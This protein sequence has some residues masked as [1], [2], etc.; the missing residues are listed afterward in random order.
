MSPIPVSKTKIIPP[1]RRDE[2]LARKRL[3]DM[4]FDALDKKL[5]LVSAP[6]GYGKTSLL[7]DLVK[8]TEL[9]CCW[10]SLDELDREPERFITYFIAS[11]AECFPGVGNQT[12]AVMNGITSL[13]DEMERL[14]V[15]LVNE[16]FALAKEHFVIILDDFHIL[17]DV[18]PIHSLLNRFIQLV[19]DNC[20]IIISSRTLAALPDLPLMVARE[21][22]SGLS[23]FDL[24]FR[25]EEFQA[26]ILQ[27]HRKHISDQ[28]AQKLID[29]TEGWIT[30]LQFSGNNFVHK[31]KSK[32]ILASTGV[33]LFD[34]LGQQVVDKLK[35]ELQ[36][37]LLRTSLMDEFDAQLCEK[38]LAG[39][40]R[41][42]QDWDGYIKA[43]TQN[44][45]FALPVGADGRSLRYHHLFRDYLR[46]R[47]ER[48]KKSEIKV[49]LRNLGN[50]YES[51]GEWEK[52]HYFV[53][54]L[55][56][57]NALAAI[58]E[59]ACFSISQRSLPATETW[60][61]EL[62]PS[63][64][65]NRPGI[66]SI[67]GTLLYMKGDFEKGLAL[68]T[69]AEN[70]FRSEGNSSDLALMLIRRA[71][72]YRFLGN[73]PN[74][75]KDAEEV[76]QITE[77]H[78]TM[79]SLYAEALRVKGLAL[80]RL[81]NSKQSVKFLE[82][83]LDAYI[84]IK[85]QI[86]IPL[87]LMETGM[88]Y[89]SLGK[90]AEASAAYE[91]AL[92]IWKQE[93]N[94][95]RQSN[96][97]NNMGVMYHIQGEYG[98]SASAYE[99]GLLCARRSSYKRLEALISIG[100]GDL[101]AELQDFEIASQNYQ[102]ASTLI[103]EMQEHFLL[104]SLQIGQ[105]NMAL[106]QN[107]KEK[108]SEILN[109][110]GEKM[111]L[112]Q[113]HYEN[114]N[115]HLLSGKKFILEKR[116]SQAV[117][118]LEQAE[119]HFIED[120]RELECSITRIWLAAAFYS[121]NDAANAS[122]KLKMAIND[123]SKV[124]PGL[125]VAICQARLWLEGLERDAEIGRLLRDLFVRSDRLTD[126]LPSIRRELRRQSRVLEMPAP[127]LSIH[128]LGRS[129]V[130]IAGHV[131]NISD[132]QTQSVRDLFFFF[133][134]KS[135]PLT[136]EQ[137]AEIIWPDI[138]EP[139]KIRLRFKNEIYRLRRAIGQEAILFEN[140]FY[141]FNRS[142]DYEYDVEAFESYL[143]KIKSVKSVE[144][145]IE[146]Y[147]KA[148]DLVHGPYLEDM[149]FDWI[150]PDRE[151]LS[152]MYLNAL[153]ALADLYQKRALLEEGLSLCRRAI[154]YRPTFEAAYTLSMQ[155]YHRLGDRP[156]IIRM[157]QA[158]LDALQKLSMDPSNE[159]L[160]LYQTLIS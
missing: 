15:T 91:K 10:L 127:H 112:N 114:G 82:N 84:A 95:L 150:F 157:Y 54:Q 109:E 141:S 16:C 79:R 123:G 7:I 59:R 20:H 108:A 97:L 158:C 13:E 131:L 111:S 77:G 160:T 72:G 154:D 65:N 51:M 151:R 145:Q 155:I 53:K 152:Q 69:Q 58:I 34:F 122:K 120:G 68:F 126:S 87:L 153:V 66:L 83:S 62:P 128:A 18:K 2:L 30:G 11:I 76:I 52:A 113:S 74:S 14:A 9:R 78:D 33:G 106:L 118:S 23:F 22:V 129:A 88:A 27:N 73:Y 89:D 55:D 57:M 1:R 137:I 42:K 19:D 35:P 32:P 100:L 3:L 142:M 4:L 90:Y 86:G 102:H 38:V 80:F 39:F 75:I 21:Q 12:L 121:N 94:L 56:D 70:I 140:V 63:I 28:D 116:M 133:L 17:E 115:F 47:M 104:F 139:S 99:D 93:G 64:L 110:M 149:Y 85:D 71:S 46:V 136:K 61:N 135:K 36:E 25:K 5:V 138:D 134:T 60:L 37:F 119:M 26:L 101:Y 147:K 159:T 8:Q 98:K 44:N 49:I 132:W 148:I 130:S 103:A 43:I 31:E 146:L 117:Q 125:L 92:E 50:A 40:Y 81:G 29:E 45:L 144:E 107:N 96:L 48:E 156:S 105:A 6:A 24:S 41:K 143:L 124:I 67:R